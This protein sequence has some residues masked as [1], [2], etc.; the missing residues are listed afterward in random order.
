MRILCV[1]HGTEHPVAV[2]SQRRYAV[3]NWS[4]AAESPLRADASRSSSKVSTF[5]EYG[6]LGSSVV[7]HRQL[8]PTRSVFDAF[9][10][11]GGL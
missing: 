3:T 9:H 2:S 8:V 5:G 11:A 7:E 4:N 10:A 6:Y 1:V